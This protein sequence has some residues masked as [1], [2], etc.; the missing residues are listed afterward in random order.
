[1]PKYY[2]PVVLVVEA[3]DIL[4]ASVTPKKIVDKLME[5]EVGGVQGGAYPCSF[6]PSFASPNWPYLGQAL[7]VDGD[8][9]EVVEV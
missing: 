3:A 1:M 8:I 2:V 7:R 9:V 5:L 4:E 6:V